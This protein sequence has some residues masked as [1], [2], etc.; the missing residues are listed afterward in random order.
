MFERLCAEY[1][2]SASTTG[3][4]YAVLGLLCVAFAVAMLVLAFR[5]S[6]EWAAGTVFGCVAAI[7]CFCISASN[8]SDVNESTDYI[9]NRYRRVV[10]PG[11]SAV[12][13]TPDEFFTR[14]HQH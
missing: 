4:W 6:E 14:M 3:W 1:V 5:G 7:I 8:F 10:D 12:Y 2:A 9:Y 13:E 11:K